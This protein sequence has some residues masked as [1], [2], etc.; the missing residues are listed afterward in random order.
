VPAEFRRLDRDRRTKARLWG[1]IHRGG[2]KSSQISGMRICRHPDVEP[3][4]V[5]CDASA[6]STTGEDSPNAL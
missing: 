2:R 4:E 1:V 5:P 3:S 6:T